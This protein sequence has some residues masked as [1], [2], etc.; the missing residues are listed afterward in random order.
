MLAP[1]SIELVGMADFI[2]NSIYDVLSFA[3]LDM[4]PDF[5]SNDGSYHP[6]CE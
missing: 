5:G 6:S 1:N 4:L 3:G 2:H